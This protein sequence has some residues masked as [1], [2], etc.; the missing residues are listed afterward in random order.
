MLQGEVKQLT[1]QLVGCKMQLAE[2][3]GRELQLA[4]DVRGLLAK[5]QREHEAAAEE[6][7]LAGAVELEG[8]A[9]GGAA[10]GWVAGLFWRSRA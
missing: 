10:A 9:R 2:S 5:L 6:E 3:Q 7:Q 4:Q 8:Y 1:E